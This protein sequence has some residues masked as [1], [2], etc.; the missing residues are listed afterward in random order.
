MGDN[1]KHETLPENDIFYGFENLMCLVINDCP[2]YGSLPNWLSK[3]K[4]LEALI[5]RDNQLS[6]PIPGWINS[7]NFL[8]YLDISN[9]SLTGDIPAG[10]MEISMLK[11]AHSDPII[12]KMPVY[13]SPF[14]QYITS[15]SVPKM[16]NLGNNKFTGVIPPQIGQLK[17]LLSLN[18]SFNNLYGEI[19]QSISNL[20]NLQVL[21]LSYNNLTVQSLLHW[22]TF[23]SFPNSTFQTMI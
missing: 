13:L 2:L 7:L 21:D 4:K 6:G 18:L 12:L 9:N 1:F 15:S 22:R 14:H 16:L 3:L 23:T 11:S 17:A 10:L 19:P 8:F 20:T 5:L